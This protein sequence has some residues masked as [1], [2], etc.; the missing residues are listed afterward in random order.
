MFSNGS[1]IQPGKLPGPTHWLTSWLSRCASLTSRHTLL[2]ETVKNNKMVGLAKQSA[3][4]SH[5]NQVPSH[6]VLFR[7]Q[8]RGLHISTLSSSLTRQSSFGDLTQTGSL[9]VKGQWDC[10]R[11]SKSTT[12]GALD[13]FQAILVQFTF[14]LSTRT[15]GVLKY[16]VDP[17]CM[18][19]CYWM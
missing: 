13:R 16:F 6:V 2:R 3:A 4:K 17:F 19:Y 12:C 5:Y 15:V 7:D 1:C 14:N 9:F 11:T 18:C 10:L 8:G